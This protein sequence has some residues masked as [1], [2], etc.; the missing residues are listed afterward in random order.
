M[1]F[2]IY[3]LECVVMCFVFTAFTQGLLLWNPLTFISDYPP[4]IQEAYYRSQ[5]KE[6]LK[7]KLTVIML[8]KKCIALLVFAF[9]FAWMAHIAGAETFLH[10]LFCTYGY[11]IIL[12]AYDTFFLDWVLFANMKKIR[13]PGTEDMDKEYHQKWFHV[14][15]CIPMIPVFIMA[16]I[17]V[18]YVM[19]V[20]W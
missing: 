1:N 7:E 15:V 12:L 20:I 19:T 10:G 8:V 11:V 2:Q 6:K 17:V 16:G 3:A 18:S 4:E 9:L 5:N 13:L 14:K